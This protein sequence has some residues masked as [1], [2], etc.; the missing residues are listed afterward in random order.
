VGCS[1]RGRGN[2]R[3]QETPQRDKLRPNPHI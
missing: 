3:R 2:R 1:L